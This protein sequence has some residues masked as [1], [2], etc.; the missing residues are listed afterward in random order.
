MH[1]SGNNPINTLFEHFAILS[2][3]STLSTVT[4]V[5]SLRS[6]ISPP[7][8][9]T[10]LIATPRFIDVSSTGIL[11]DLYFISFL[12]LRGAASLF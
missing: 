1:S 9:S 7:I 11:H 6:N 5:P 10:L 8:D 12:I 3:V 4:T 2:S